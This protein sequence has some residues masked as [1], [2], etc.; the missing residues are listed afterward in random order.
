MEDNAILCEA[1]QRHGEI[2]CDGMELN[3][4]ISGTVAPRI[5][6][7]IRPEEEEDLPDDNQTPYR[8]MAARALYLAQDRLDIQYEANELCIDMRSPKVRSWNALKS[9]VRYLK[10]YPRMVMEFKRHG[11]NGHLETWVDTYYAG[12]D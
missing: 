3:A 12:C 1:D 2:M 11:H 6:V 8:A 9:V 4:I 10:L 7:N 5:H